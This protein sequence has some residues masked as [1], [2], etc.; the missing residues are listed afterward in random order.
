MKSETQEHDPLLEAPTAHEELLHEESDS[1][2]W[3][4]EVY[5]TLATDTGLMVTAIVYTL[6]VLLNVFALTVGVVDPHKLHDWWMLLIEVF[7]TSCLV[8][9]VVFKYVFATYVDSEQEFWDC[10]NIT[11]VVIVAL[12]IAATVVILAKDRKQEDDADDAEI[13]LRVGRDT[14]RFIRTLLFMRTMMRLQVQFCTEEEKCTP[15]TSKRKLD[16]LL[17]PDAEATFVNSESEGGRSRSSSPIV[18][19]DS[20][21]R[22]LY[23]ESPL[24]KDEGTPVL[25]P[26]L[27]SPDRFGDKAGNE[28]KMEKDFSIGDPLLL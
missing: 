19:K 21:Q 20:R 24:K 25:S 11:D 7:L 16:N 4:R 28:S 26:S 17:L 5:V 12:S 27:G 13:G 6:L 10:E 8:I 1:F 3:V 22:S 18:T 2:Q 23:D 9:E 14:V 15:L